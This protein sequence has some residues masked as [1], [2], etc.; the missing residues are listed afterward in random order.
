MFKD[1]QLKVYSHILME[2]PLTLTL[3][4]WVTW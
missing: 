2:T 4:V 1:I 3:R